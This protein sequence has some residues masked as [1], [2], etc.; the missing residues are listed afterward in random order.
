MNNLN[1]NEHNNIP[2]ERNVDTLGSPDFS[3]I[4]DFIRTH[5]R[6][7]ALDNFDEGLARPDDAEPYPEPPAL[8]HENEYY[9]DS[10]E[11]NSSESSESPYWYEPLRKSSK[12][13]DRD[14]FSEIRSSSDSLNVS[15]EKFVDKCLNISP[16]TLEPYTEEDADLFIVYIQDKNGKFKNANGIIK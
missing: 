3:G 16:L 13:E 14:L 6:R 4:S 1:E 12:E 8:P 5:S 15:S 7:N 11:F 9:T 10:E 2:L